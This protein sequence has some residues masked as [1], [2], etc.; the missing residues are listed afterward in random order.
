[1]K[2]LRTAVFLLL[3][4]APCTLS[5][6]S[7]DIVRPWEDLCSGEKP[8]NSG[9]VD[10]FDLITRSLDKDDTDSGFSLPFDLD[11][12]FS[13]SNLIDA[14]EF[15]GGIRFDVGLDRIGIGLDF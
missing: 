11:R 8:E 5:A 2:A 10:P 6:G 13:F 9:Y 7:L 4:A 15:P 1:M 3:A 12:L 14:F